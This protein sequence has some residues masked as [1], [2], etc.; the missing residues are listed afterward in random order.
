MPG[1][2]AVKHEAEE[3]EKLP[4]VTQRVSKMQAN[5][6][7]GASAQQRLQLGRVVHPSDIPT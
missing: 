2:S 1:G 3:I 7:G 6:A 4:M 5:V